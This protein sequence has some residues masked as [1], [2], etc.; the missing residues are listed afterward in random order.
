M[1]S[2]ITFSPESQNKPENNLNNID[3]ETMGFTDAGKV[4][5][6]AAAFNISLER[7]FSRLLL[8]RDTQEYNIGSKNG[9]AE[10]KINMTKEKITAHSNEITRLQS[11]VL[12]EAEA[13][14]MEAT[15][16][17]NEF[18]INPTKF[19]KE[20]E[21]RLLLWIYGCLSLFITVFLYFFYSS[22]IYSAVFRDISITKYTIFNSIFYP[23][24]IEE[25]SSKGLAAFMLVLFAPFIFLGLGLAI[26]HVKAKK[27][28]KY[29]YAWVGVAL[30]TF[31]VDA[32]L[33]Y[34]ISER[35]YNS[36]A[37]NTFG[38]VQ[39][40]TLF[41]AFV[42]LNFW[43]IIAL[44]FCVYIL[45][46]YIFSLYN[47]QRSNKNKFKDFEKILLE[48]V[49]NASNVVVN[50]KEDIK[51]LEEKIYSLNVSI[52]EVH[53]EY[54]KIFYSPNELI[55]II[56]DYALGWIKY[57]QNARTPES[58]IQKI[59]YALNNFYTQKGIK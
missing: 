4:G 52:S 46:G 23:K 2:I 39:P 48:K 51:Q 28:N 40:F 20:E 22:V 7:F 58:E 35:I 45:F 13:N 38:N 54:D 55:K 50:I 30:F 6:S 43:I 8:N 11:K 5:G 15:E 26:E 34:H 57:L 3:F 18:K 12:P 44:G 16:T 9:E 32:L 42:D 41:D 29:Q 49:E 24:A 31:L 27:N 56:S 14:L 53:K 10:I 19:V 36:K 21:D 47:E 25:A 59:E 33:A 1:T 37:I 17:M